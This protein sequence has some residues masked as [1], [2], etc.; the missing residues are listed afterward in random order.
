MN[1]PPW[2]APAL[3]GLLRHFY[4]SMLLAQGVSIKELSAYLGHA[5]AGFTLRVYTRMV[6]S[7]HDRA[8]LAVDLLFHEQQ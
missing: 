4:A 7:S 6:P 2:C 3:G 5:D 1:R 8:R